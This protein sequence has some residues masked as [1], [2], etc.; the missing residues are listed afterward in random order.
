MGTLYVFVFMCS[1]SDSS[2]A[3]FSGVSH[4]PIASIYKERR[5]LSTFYYPVCDRVTF[6]TSPFSTFIFSLYLTSPSAPFPV[7][8]SRPPFLGRS[9]RSHP[10]IMYPGCA[11]VSLCAIAWACISG[12]CRK[13]GWLTLMATRCLTEVWTHTHT[14]P[15]THTR[16]P[17]SWLEKTDEGSAGAQRQGERQQ[18]SESMK[19]P[20][21][22]WHTGNGEQRKKEKS[23][24]FFSFYPKTKAWVFFSPQHGWFWRYKHTTWVRT[25]DCP[26]SSEGFWCDLRSKLYS[27]RC[28]RC[29][30]HSGICVCVHARVCERDTERVWDAETP[31]V[32]AEIFIGIPSS[33]VYICNFKHI[34]HT[35]RHTHDEFNVLKTKGSF[36]QH[37]RWTVW[38]L[39]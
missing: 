1:S 22:D 37:D 11:C 8:S 7:A 6:H 34:T 10:A 29:S 15:D 25:D 12:S 32:R 2:P 27:A 30:F 39:E 20:I 28:F 16:T 21:R 4:L 5:R 3:A 26:V 24:Q 31:T 36:R 19:T 13:L 17:I 9:V 18:Q 35:Q 14:N 33:T 23:I 38:L